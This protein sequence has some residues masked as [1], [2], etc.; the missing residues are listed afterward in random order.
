MCRSMCVLVCVEAQTAVVF[1]VT[2]G[3]QG[4]KDSEEAAS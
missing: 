4:F 1:V 2:K 3:L